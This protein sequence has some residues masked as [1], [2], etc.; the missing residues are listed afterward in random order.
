MSVDKFKFEKKKIF[1]LSNNNRYRVII[2]EILFRTIKFNSSFQYSSYNTSYIFI[3]GEPEKREIFY[4]QSDDI[5]K[6][7][8]DSDLGSS[9]EETIGL[10]Q[11]TDGI[12]QRILD[13]STLDEQLLN[14]GL[15]RIPIKG[16][17]NCFFR[18]ILD[19]LNEDQDD[20]ILIRWRATKYIRSNRNDFPRSLVG[21]IEKM[22]KDGT[23]ADHPLIL[24][25]ARHMK[26]VIF[27]HEN[28]K[29]P[30]LIPGTYSIKRQV[31]VA[32]DPF[33]QHYESVRTLNGRRPL[34]L[35][36]T[37]QWT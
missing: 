14:I 36:G 31:H 24:A 34:L 33:R 22:E 35:S 15:K 9:P 4:K 10:S 23:Y 8:D 7:G 25:T 16:D 17:G 20:H 12:A 2:N 27:I 5:E 19:Q 28:G 21:D 13:S 3:L 1:L 29:H 32:Y 37:F 30:L 18:A 11:T 6:P 26:I